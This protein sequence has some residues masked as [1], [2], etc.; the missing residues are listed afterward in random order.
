MLTTLL[1][2]YFIAGCIIAVSLAV[3]AYNSNLV[4]RWLQRLQQTPEQKDFAQKWQQIEQMIAVDNELA[5]RAAIVE[6]DKLL[7]YALKAKR[8]AGADLGGRLKVAGY[9]FNTEAAW[10]AHKVRNRLVHDG[11]FHLTKAQA[12][13]ALINYKKALK[14]LGAF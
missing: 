12:Q 9:K 3:I 8:L 13:A 5:Y 2:L 6:A 1:P 4:Q 7:D 11:D 10:Q 14:N